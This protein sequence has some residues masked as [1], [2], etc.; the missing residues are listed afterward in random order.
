MNRRYNEIYAKKLV[1]IHSAKICA[2]PISYH[3]NFADVWWIPEK[4]FTKIF[5]E[6]E[7]IT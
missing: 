2:Y 5:K 4:I 7:L 6:C 3:L 1:R